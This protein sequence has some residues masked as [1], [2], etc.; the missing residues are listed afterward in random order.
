M[1]SSAHRSPTL[2]PG[3]PIAAW[4]S[5]SL[6]AVILKGRLPLRP[7]ASRLEWTAY[8]TSRGRRF[9]HHHAAAH[10]DRGENH[11]PT[12]TLITAQALNGGLDRPDR[13]KRTVPV[14][15]PEIVSIQV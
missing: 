13:N 6:A 4:A 9:R 11:D 12:G 3:L 8:L 2:V 1:R 15:L 5:R 14:Y 10:T 7:R